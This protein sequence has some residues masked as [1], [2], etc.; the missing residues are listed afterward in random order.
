MSGFRLNFPW[1]ILCLGIGFLFI[2]WAFSEGVIGLQLSYEGRQLLSEF[3]MILF[4]L[5]IPV[6][7]CLM[8]AFANLTHKNRKLIKT[9]VIF[10]GRFNP[11]KRYYVDYGQYFFLLPNKKTI[12][13]SGER[14]LPLKKG[15]K[16]MIVY[17]GL[18]IF[19]VTRIPTKI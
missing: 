7:A 6:S 17:R 8:F 12:L 15:D 9:P 1:I 2:G 14:N 3:F 19:E 11:T 10:I 13:L 18:Y 16:L 5:S 4:F